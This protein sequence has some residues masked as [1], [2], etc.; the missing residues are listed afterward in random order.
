VPSFKI[1][2]GVA[3]LYDYDPPDCAIKANVLGEA[4]PRGGLG[5]LQPPC[6]GSL[7]VGWS[8]GEEERRGERE[9]EGERRRERKE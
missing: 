7:Q 8:K 3:G 1:Y 6:A 2:G 4:D 9:R 5:G